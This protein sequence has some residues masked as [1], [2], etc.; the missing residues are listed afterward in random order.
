MIVSLLVSAVVANGFDK[1]W[2]APLVLVTLTIIIGTTM[3]VTLKN[4][5]RAEIISHAK[6][7]KTQVLDH[8]PHDTPNVFVQLTS[9]EIFKLD[10]TKIAHF[11]LFGILGGLLHFLRGR[12][13]LLL[14][15]LDISIVS[16]GTELMQL[17]IDGRSALVGDVLIDLAGASC[18]ILMLFI[19]QHIMG[20][21]A[22]NLKQS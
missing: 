5:A 11:I 16:S 13:L 17:F 4:E 12:T 20:I 18:V 19:S 21:F 3:P 10:I 22:N 1:K 9:L 14:T 6:T 8:I 7:F 15:L 2:F